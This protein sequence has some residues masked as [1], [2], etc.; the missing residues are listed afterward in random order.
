L[1][2]RVVEKAALSD[3]GRARQ[4]NED[5]YLERSP[6]FAVADGMGGARAGE[7]ASGIAVGTFDE[8]PEPDASPEQRL[9]AVATAANERIYSLAQEDA[10]YAGMGTTFTA[11]LVTGNEIAIGH[12][13]DSRL[14]RYRDGELERLTDDHSL[15]E[16]FVR[17]GKLTPEEAEVHPQRSII[18][19]ALGP[20][21]Q[22]EVDTFTYPARAGDTYLAC[23]DGLTG[24]I[25]ETDVAQ[26]L[27]VHE[28]LSDAAQALIDAANANGGRDNITV[29][30]FRLGEDDGTA[31]E[32]DTLGDQAT[33]V[34]ISADEV[35]AAV[36]EA[37]N[38]GGTQRTVPSHTVPSDVPDEDS[39][40]HLR[41]REATRARRQIKIGR[42]RVSD[43]GVGVPSR[44]PPPFTRSSRRPPRRRAR[45]LLSLLLTLV[46][47]GALIV[48]IK[49]LIDSR[50]FVGTNDSGL[51]T[52][53]N[54][55]PYDLPLGI[56][57]YSER[58]VSPVPARTLPGRQR[59]R[60]LD[61]QLR[62][63]GDATD[64]V[65]QI[66]RGSLDEN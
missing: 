2:L 27:S 53:Y 48:G 42:D 8:E 37:E 26:I 7:V 36:A 14:Y 59:Q 66:E 30:L 29:V 39:T 17:Q 47:L 45:T 55:V 56:K 16:E 25:S 9:A 23:S 62:S 61:H 20:E 22:V 24:M 35:R 32:G 52:I 34:G 43:S 12:V 58:Y 11:V 49:A 4:G 63:K 50:Y 3:V 1:A 41:G 51:V 21:P 33:Q 5:S 54:G 31:D 46:I 15:V 64:L 40:L 18:T 38:G 57:L 65:R 13:G 60:I 6:L 19:R 44:S 28:N 10:S